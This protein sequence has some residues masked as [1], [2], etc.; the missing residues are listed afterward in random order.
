MKII[1]LAYFNDGR[2]DLCD[3]N[4]IY[5]FTDASKTAWYAKTLCFAVQHQMVSGY[6][7][8]TFR[9]DATINLAEAAKIVASVDILD[10]STSPTTTIHLPAGEPWYAGYMKYLDE[11]NAMPATLVPSPDHL[12]TRG[13][14]A[15]IIFGLQYRYKATQ[16][17]F[18]RSSDVNSILNTL[19]MYSIDSEGTLPVSIPEHPT[20]ICAFSECTGSYV[21]LFALVSN[22]YL[23]RI[24]R[25]P[26]RTSG[27]GTGYFISKDATNGRITIAAQDAELRSISVTY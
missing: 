2:L 21:N 26:S 20:E 3:P 11:H 1:V 7:D 10:I 24:P 25:D 4:H 5:D 18:Q 9:P 22:Y 16:R 14:M 23:V 12:L 27:M 15:E 19:R 8:N 6:G 17:D 13:E